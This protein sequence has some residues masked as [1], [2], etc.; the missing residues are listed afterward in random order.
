[1]AS[2]G[3]L[4]NDDGLACDVEVCSMFKI[5]PVIGVTL[6]TFLLAYTAFQFPTTPATSPGWSQVVSAVTSNES[7]TPE[8]QAT[9]PPTAPPKIAS[10][11]GQRPNEPGYKMLIRCLSDLDDLLDT[12]RDP[13][14]FARIKPQLRA[15]VQQHVAQVA[16]ANGGM[17]RLSRAAAKEMQKAMNRHT[18]SML[19]ANQVAPGVRD[20]FEHEIAGLLKAN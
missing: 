18:Q 14:T 3:V 13:T 1:V 8:P 2:R 15:R 6:G 4:A 20:F 16:H 5:V 7:I 12:V 9:A 19:Q 17:A 10:D 11:G